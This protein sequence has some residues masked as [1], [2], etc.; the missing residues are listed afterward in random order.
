MINWSSYV[1]TCTLT[2]ISFS[3]LSY[4]FCFKWRPTLCSSSDVMGYY[5]K[6][7]PNHTFTHVTRL[8]VRTHSAHECPPLKT[9]LLESRCLQ[10][11][12]VYWFIYLWTRPHVWRTFHYHERIYECLYKSSHAK[13]KILGYFCLAKIFSL[14]RGILGRSYAKFSSGCF[15]LW[16]DG[17]QNHDQVI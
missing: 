5:V 12:K 16:M 17:T 13:V 6:A 7:C 3:A 4:L 11:W 14:R 8:S 10:P 1:C 2:L 9:T 15:L